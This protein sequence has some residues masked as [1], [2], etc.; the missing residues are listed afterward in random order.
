MDY[1]KRDLE[2]KIK[3]LAEDYSCILTE[4]SKNSP[5]LYR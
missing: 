1:I 2:E 4:Y 5:T 3:A